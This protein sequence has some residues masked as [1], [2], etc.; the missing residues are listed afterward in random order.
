MDL[1]LLIFIQLLTFSDVKCARP[2][3]NFKEGS[4]FQSIKCSANNSTARV[5]YCF[6]KAVSRKIVTLN[7][8][9]KLL[10]SINKPLYVQLILYFRY[11]LIYREVINT[12]KQEWCDIMDGKSTNLYFSHTIA[13]IKASAPGLFHKCPYEGDVDVKNLTVDDHKAFDIFPEG[14]YKNSLMVFDKNIEPFFSLNL[15]SHLKSSLKESLG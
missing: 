11:G 3:E 5:N 15:T 14:F 10:K 1:K 13:Q 2:A 8:G 6:I 4:R 12:K 9:V 7:V